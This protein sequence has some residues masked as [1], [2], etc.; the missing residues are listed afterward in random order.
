[1]DRSKFESDY[2][3]R[4]ADRA[5]IS[6]TYADLYPFARAYF[7]DETDADSNLISEMWS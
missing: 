1:M 7:N 2:S 5:D 6:K 4:A 3:K